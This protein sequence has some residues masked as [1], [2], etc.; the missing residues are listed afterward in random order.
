MK[1]T[2]YIP[3]EMD[4]RIDDYLQ[5][6]PDET[7]SSIIQEA[8][9]SKLAQKDVSE[10][11]ALAGIVKGGACNARDRAEDAVFSKEKP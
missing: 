10:L 7:L 6:H 5:E 11:L 3:D 1:R 9:Q 4:K 8:I 2:V